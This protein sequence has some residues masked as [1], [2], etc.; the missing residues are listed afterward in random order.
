MAFNIAWRY[1]VDIHHDGDTYL[2]PWTWLNY[3]KMVIEQQLKT[4]IFR[5]LTDQ[6]VKAFGV[7]TSNQRLDSTAVRSRRIK[8]P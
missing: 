6:L 8:Q 4:V 3:R 2:R 7:E 1:A 5:A